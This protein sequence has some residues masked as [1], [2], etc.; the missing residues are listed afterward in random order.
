M[1]CPHE[2]DNRDENNTSFWCQKK[3]KQ[4]FFVTP[5]NKDGAL[6]LQYVDPQV[7]KS[8]YSFV[9]DNIQWDKIQIVNFWL[10][11][12][13]LFNASTSFGLGNCDHVY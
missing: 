8:I 10:Q 7:R 5:N 12:V 6:W 4:N 3:K 11:M 2:F 13:V 9:I 1:K